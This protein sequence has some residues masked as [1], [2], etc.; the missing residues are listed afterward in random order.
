MHVAHLIT[1]VP[2]GIVV[3]IVRDLTVNNLNKLEVVDNTTSGH[4]SCHIETIDE[5]DI[6]DNA[7]P[8]VLEIFHSSI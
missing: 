7:L 1:V 6:D 5:M 4:G 2:A 3:L 8:Y